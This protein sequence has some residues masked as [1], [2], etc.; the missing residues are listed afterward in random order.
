MAERWETVNQI[1]KPVDSLFALGLDALRHAGYY[2]PFRERLYNIIKGIQRSGFDKD[3]NLEII[4]LE[5]VP[6]EGGAI[7]APNHQSWL[8]VQVLVASIPRRVRFVAKSMFQDWPMLRH[9]IDMSDS[10]YIQR[11]GDSDGLQAVADALAGGSLVGVFPEGTIPGEENFARWDVEPE[12]GLLKGKTGVVR[13]AL[14]A[15]VQVIPVGI[16]G[17]GKSLPPE[18]YPRLQQL[19]VKKP[20][21]ITIRFGKPIT[22]E[23]KDINSVNRKQLREMTDEVMRAI[24][25]LIDHSRGFVPIT[26]PVERKTKPARTPTFALRSK[27]TTRKRKSP[28][29]ALVLHGFTSHISCVSPIEDL[30]KDRKIPYRFPLLRGH[31]TRYED[32][33]G[34]TA[35]DWYE[36]AEDAMLELLQEC[37]QVILIGHSMGGLLAL[38]LAAHWNDKVRA[39]VPVAPAIKF[40]DPLTALTPVLAKLFGFW[41]S[42]NAFVDPEL[43]KNSRN[44]PKFATD[45][46]TELYNYGGEVINRLSFVRVPVAVLHTRKDQVVAPRSA[47]IVLSKVSSKD[48]EM[49]WFDK[50]GHEMF[51]DLE[52]DAVT[53]AVGRCIDRFL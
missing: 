4:G 41:P 12:T 42:P 32:L 9:L 36:D 40:A 13:L 30:L 27:P 19:P 8:D 53:A 49:V 21:P 38:D 3:H 43:A 51:M 17:T 7:L 33:V 50:S 10:I 22:F 11:G 47:D 25:A 37:E 14:M 23:G 35:K 26:V 39:V 1:A 45:A 5:N 20:A 16:S 44:Y 34:V 18:S 48:K 46:F 28:V 31:G 52:A 29:G 6:L 24:S 2:D 15:G